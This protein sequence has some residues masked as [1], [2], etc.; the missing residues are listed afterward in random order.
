MKKL[1]YLT[2]SIDPRDYS[3]LLK[4]GI[5]TANPSNQ[6]FHAK[7]I[8]AISTNFE[9]SVISFV[10]FDTNN[11]T[12]V[13]NSKYTYIN[14]PK[15]ILDK[16]FAY[17]ELKTACQKQEGPFEAI[18]F[19]PMNIAL[20]KIAIYARKMFKAPIIP[21]LTD[22]PYNI[23]SLPEKK[24][25]KM[26]SLAKE[27]D[28]SITLAQSLT[29]IFGLEA[30]P[31]KII[32]G[33]ADEN[34]IKAFEA[35]KP[36]FYFAG[37]L[38]EKY[39]V[40]TLIDSYEDS[41]LDQDLYI[42]GHGKSDVSGNKNVHFLGQVSYEE[43][44]AY[45]KGA[46][47]VINPRPYDQKLDAESVPSKMFEYIA[48]AKAIISTEN[49]FFEKEFGAQINWIGDGSSNDFAKLWN[50][51]KENG[52]LEISDAARKEFIEKYNCESFTE[53]VL[54]LLTLLTQAKPIQ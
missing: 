11:K 27:A 32:P 23:S 15:N 48:N 46:I 34:D 4:N 21:I 24:A 9:V 17:K 13:S 44:V 49:A 36:Y 16:C 1:L 5:H 54:S 33:I 28:A 6:N 47:A 50:N 19:D 26:I 29:R 41:A 53:N 52:L 25:H 43:N 39:G 30:K 38:L 8:K 45:Q 14:H 35:N 7:A 3:F 42:A 37:S 18:I 20:C 2:T 10:P 51:Y 31:N 40:K 22:N 12:L